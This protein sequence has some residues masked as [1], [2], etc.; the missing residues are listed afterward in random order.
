MCFKSVCIFL[1]F[2]KKKI[3]NYENIKYKR[4]KNVSYA[5]MAVKIIKMT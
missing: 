5:N 4:L 1:K 2:D 3:Y